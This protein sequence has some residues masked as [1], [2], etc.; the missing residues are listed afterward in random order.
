MG[1]SALGI[2]GYAWQPAWSEYASSYTYKVP[3]KTGNETGHPPV[4]SGSLGGA[5]TS[6]FQL[7]R[8][9][10][11]NVKPLAPAAASAPSGVGKT[12]VFSCVVPPSCLLIYILFQAYA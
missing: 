3:A 1:M 8:T 6:D 4:M 2:R 5:R 7:L 11:L 9:Y 12:S 10:P